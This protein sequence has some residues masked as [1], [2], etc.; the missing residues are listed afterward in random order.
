[1]RKLAILLVLVLVVMASGVAMAKDNDKVTICH[2]PPGDPW[3]PQTIRVS[4]NAWEAGHSPHNAHELD[5]EGECLPANVPPDEPSPTST[6]VVTEGCITCE[7]WIGVCDQP[8]SAEQI[9]TGENVIIHI[10]P[11]E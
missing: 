2:V 10:I 4:R 5:Y 1:M 7:K 9:I 3:N 6:A 11:K 8:M